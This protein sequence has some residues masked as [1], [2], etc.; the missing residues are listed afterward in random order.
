MKSRKQ[1]KMNFLRINYSIFVNVFF[2]FEI[3]LDLLQ[4]NVVKLIINI[5]KCILN[6]LITESV[7]ENE[8]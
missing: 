7:Y 2:F 1:R 6:R 5:I 8:C 3:K 4:Y